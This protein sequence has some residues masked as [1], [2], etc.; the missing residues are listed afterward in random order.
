LARV[1]CSAAK[2]FKSE[3]EIIQ[4]FRKTGGFFLAMHDVFRFRSLDELV[5]RT[6]SVDDMP[7]TEGTTRPVL[8]DS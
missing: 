7:A 3:N 6:M 5:P 1:T 4:L 8:A 2:G